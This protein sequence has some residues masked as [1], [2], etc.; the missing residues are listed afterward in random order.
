MT[1]RLPR[2][3]RLEGRLD[4][5]ELLVLTAF[6]AASLW[7]LALDIWQ[8]VAHGRTWTGT[9]GVYLAD[10]LQYL[11]WVKDAAHHFLASNLFV[12][13][14]TPADYFQPA[15]ALS[16]GLS[17]AGLAPWLALLLWKPVA[18]GASFFAV[19]GYVK[20]SLGSGWRARAALV[21]ALFF[22]SFTVL[23]GS[24][25]AIGDLWPVFLS[26]GYVFALL[27]VAAVIAALLAHARALDPRAR[28]QSRLAWMPALLGAG[29]SLVHPWQG[30]LLILTVLGSEL[31]LGRARPAD[32]RR[33][34]LAAVTI[35]GTAL[36]LVYYAVLGRADL[37]WRLAREASKHAFPLWSI[38][39]ALAPLLLA[40][41][42]AYRRR[43]QTFL[44]AATR[45]WPAA[46]L[47]VYAVSASALGATPLHAFGGITIP[48]S[49]L[50]VEGVAGLDRLPA[51][52]ARLLGALAIAVFTLPAGVY[53]LAN[54]RTLVAPRQGTARFIARGERSALAFLRRDP[55][56]GGV[57]ARSY[58]GAL[59]PAATGRHTFVGNCLW[60]EPRCSARLVAVRELF[61]GGLAAGPAR[62]FVA[63]ARA[64]G[65]RFLLADCRPAP[66]LR[67]L[68]E[69]LV[70]S[71]ARFGCARVYVLRAL[72]A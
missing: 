30:E 2:R 50:A 66:D 35:A 51:L 71:V 41:L 17:A 58:L 31:A 69:P 67:T 59:V 48:L 38:V 14:P 7:V 11:A 29:A 39:L 70:D 65:A 23:Y 61:T 64:A 22:G 5:F 56:R 68:L 44:D 13:H 42:P 72:R 19:R 36:P 10:Q 1:A 57:V 9:D 28:G 12:L 3:E 43:P 34:G 40:G 20:R 53:E 63:S 4:R 54:A 47:V 15:I 8:V 18:V 52:R 33:I 32:R 37:D 27:A 16:G 21:L 49:V 55:D 62:A 45:V 6:A 60:S 24:A 26:W 46:A 25:S